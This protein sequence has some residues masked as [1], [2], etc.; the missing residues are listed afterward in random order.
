MSHYNSVKWLAAGW[1]ARVWFLTGRIC[2]FPVMCGLGFVSSE[3]SIHWVTGII[4]SGVKWS[5]CE[6]DHSLSTFEEKK[7]YTIT[8]TVTIY[9]FVICTDVQGFTFLTFH[10][11]VLYAF[12]DTGTDLV[13]E[14]QSDEGGVW[15]CVKSRTRERFWEKIYFRWFCKR[16][17]LKWWSLEIM[18]CTICSWVIQEH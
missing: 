6:A 4:L 16:R 3:S 18:V 13:A 8:S 14:D 1:M 10:L 15:K 5:E 11:C 12:W 9:S 17:N 7:G 2:S